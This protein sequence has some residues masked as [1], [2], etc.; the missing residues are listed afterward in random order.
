MNFFY[1][2][3]KSFIL[4]LLYIILFPIFLT[5]MNLIKIN[6]N[7]IIIIIFGSIMMFIIGFLLGKKTNKNGYLNGLL[8]STISVFFIFILSLIFRYSI[9][10]NSLIYYL[11]LIISTIFG[12]IIGVNKKIK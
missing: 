7:K 11:I 12:S 2:Y 5:I 4:F 9:N 1:K 8:L 3:I 10:I 6:T